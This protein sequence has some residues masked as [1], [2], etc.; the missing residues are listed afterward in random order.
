MRTTL[1]IQ[2]LLAAP[3]QHGSVVSVGVFDGVH[4][5]HRAI[6]EANVLRSASLGATPTVVTFRGH[7][8]ALLLGRAPQ[9]LT[10]LQHR[11]KLFERA[12]I[13]HAV[14]LDFD[15]QLRAMDAEA[16]TNELLLGALS[17]QAFVLGFD[18]KFGHDRKGTPE[19][20]SARGL[21]VEVVPAVR[22]G[23]RAVSSTAIREAVALGD[24]AGAARM[25]GRPVTL[26]GRV[27]HGNGRGEGLGF[28]TANLDLDHEL[29]PPGGVWATR[30]RLLDEPEGEPLAAV[31]NIGHRPTLHGEPEPGSPPVVEVHILD[32]HGDLYGRRA[33]V[34]FVSF[35]RAEQRF[36][37]LDLLKSAIGADIEA[38][39]TELQS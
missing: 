30:V 34:E 9:T 32:F 7:P 39:R 20:L 29:S 10:S 33:A 15:S 8:K 18:S 31:A 14:V 4:L 17:A 16:F 22:L 25:L 21:Q 5:G 38:A 35:L 1:G 36:A 12:G 27:V 19:A 24:L 26:Q 2:A 11:L 37:S 13:G 3:A 23:G 28:P 6:L